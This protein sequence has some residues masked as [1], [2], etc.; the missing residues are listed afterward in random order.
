[1]KA[2]IIF[3]AALMLPQSVESREE[4]L[5]VDCG[6]SKI[7]FPMNTFPYGVP[8][9]IREICECSRRQWRG[10]QCDTKVRNRMLLEEIYRKNNRIIDKVL[11]GIPEYDVEL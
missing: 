7:M 3:L 11:K 4:F 8:F 5:V 2:F 9:S 1:M 6:R 10:A